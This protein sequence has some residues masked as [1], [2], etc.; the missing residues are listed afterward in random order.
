M[1]ERFEALNQVILM[2]I[3]PVIIIGILFFGNMTDRHKI[4]V[5]KAI[6]AQSVIC[7]VL[8]IIMSGTKLI[9]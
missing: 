1:K 8:L 6:I 4:D 5:K 3:P 9:S 2:R 7:G